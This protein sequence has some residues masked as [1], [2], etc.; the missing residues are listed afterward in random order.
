MDSTG[1]F[2]R[3]RRSN[4]ANCAIHKK[5]RS[6]SYPLQPCRAVSKEINPFKRMH[7]RL[8]AY[9]VATVLLLVATIINGISSNALTVSGLLM[10]PLNAI[11]VAMTATGSVDTVNQIV[12]TKKKTTNHD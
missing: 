3:S 2:R 12:E 11:M 10:C 8:W 7:T 1:H 9:I 5:T 6:G 4:H